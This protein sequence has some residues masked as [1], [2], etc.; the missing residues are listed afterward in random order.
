MSRPCLERRRSADADAEPTLSHT[1]YET[2]PT[3]SLARSPL[4]L[5]LSLSLSLFRAYSALC[6]LPPCLGGKAT[7]RPPTERRLGLGPRLRRAQRQHL[8]FVLDTQS[9]QGLV[10]AS[11]RW[12]PDRSVFGREPRRHAYASRFSSQR[13]SQR[14]DTDRSR[15]HSSQNSKPEIFQR[16]SVSPRRA[17]ILCS[18]DSQ[19]GTSA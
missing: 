8:R 18:R 13:S 2:L 14:L 1:H 16:G 4:V 12:G 10:S 17:S 5:S 19:P 11:F 9:I 7:E 15:D 6:R 3:Q